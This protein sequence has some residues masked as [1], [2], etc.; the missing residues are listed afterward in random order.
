V[1]VALALSVAS[2]SS[3]GKKAGAPTSTTAGAVHLVS[4]CAAVPQA[5]ATTLFG[6]QAKTTT[7][8]RPT[9]AVSVCGWTADSLADPNDP[10][11]ITYKVEVYT[12]Q[13]TQYYGEHDFAKPT[14][15]RGIGDRAFVVSAPDILQ[16]QVEDNGNVVS[17][18]YTVVAPFVRPAPKAT[19]QLAKFEALLR[20]AAARM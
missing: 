5:D 11:D 16:A 2:C 15:L 10:R 20:A 17:L 14:R 18:V 8:N 6:R 19:A 9:G 1:V 13:G 12:Y 7:V 3:G 4:A